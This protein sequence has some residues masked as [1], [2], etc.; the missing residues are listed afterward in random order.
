MIGGMAALQHS[1]SLDPPQ[2]PTLPPC[3]ARHC[4]VHGGHRP[5]GMVPGLLAEW[6]REP[7]ESSW[8]ARVTY[9][10]VVDG[11]WVMVEAWVPAAWLSARER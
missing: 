9:P 7:G 11:R 1:T 3:P 5:E 2:L 6:R 4:W 10:A 8:S